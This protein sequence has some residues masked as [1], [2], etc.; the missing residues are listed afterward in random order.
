MQEELDNL[1][2]NF[3]NRFNIYYVLNQVSLIWFWSHSYVCKLPIWRVAS[4]C[5]SQHHYICYITL[6]TK[7][8]QISVKLGV[9]QLKF[10]AKA[11]GI[12][13]SLKSHKGASW[14]F[15]QNLFPKLNTN[16][17][18]GGI[19][20]FQNILWKMNNLQHCVVIFFQ[21]TISVCLICLIVYSSHFCLTNWC[22]EFCSMY[23]SVAFW[24]FSFWTW[25]MS[26]Q[27][28]ALLIFSIHL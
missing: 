8:C 11:L 19:S 18:T 24:I 14:T 2:S 9:I 3:P 15:P 10:V 23:N 21:Y 4:L 26:F 5:I 6:Q 12:P 22:S 13:E 20:S 1:S 17:F 27:K 7:H 16:S 25:W 28:L